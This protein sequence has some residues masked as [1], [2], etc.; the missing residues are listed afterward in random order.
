[1]SQLEGGELVVRVLKEEGVKYIFTLCGGSIIPIYNACLDYDIKVIGVRNEQT[2]SYMADA[3]GRLTRQPGICVVTSGPGHT[4]ALTGLATAYLAHSPMILISG[5]CYLEDIEK[6]AFQEIDQ[7]G[8]AAPVTKWSKL[9]LDVKRVPEYVATAFRQATSGKPGPVHLS[10]PRDIMEGK[11]EESAVTFV[12]PLKYRSQARIRGD[13]ELIESAVRL[14]AQAERPAV[15]AG[16]GVH[17]SDANAALKEFI[18]L[19]QIPLF[20]KE[21]EIGCVNKS[22]PLY[23]GLASRR[24]NDVAFKLEQADVVLVLGL[25]LDSR[26]L[27]GQP[28]FLGERMKLIRVDLT[29]EELGRNRE[30]EIGIVGDMKSV[31]LDMIEAARKIDSWGKTAWLAELRTAREQYLARWDE[32]RHSD[33]KPVHPLRLC[34][35]IEKV[36][37]AED[38]LVTD[39]GDIGQWAKVAFYSRHPS[40]WLTVGAIGGVGCGIPFALAAQLARPKHRTILLSGDGSFGFGAMEFD[41]AVKNSIPIVAVLSNDKYWGIIRH[42]QIARYG[43]ERAIGTELGFTRYDKIV[44]ALDGYGEFV[45]NPDDIAPAIKRALDSGVPACVNVMTEFANPMYSGSPGSV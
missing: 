45:Q 32:I 28:P 11:A 31:L 38:T 21:D 1:M 41:I 5:H 44:E 39:G 4:N 27:H 25:R 42:P 30:H 16:G 9:T 26:S 12:P 10:I 18:E 6:D 37:D 34:H 23:F 15:I 33:A 29:P 36:L 20:T 19:T 24:N 17:W 40:H 13:S 43:E 35:E 7:V 8:M 22:F 14:L 2:A 3:W